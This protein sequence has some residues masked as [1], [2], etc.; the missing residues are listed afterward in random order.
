[1]V[2]LAE[3]MVSVRT[4]GQVSKPYP[5]VMVHWAGYGNSY[6]YP[7]DGVCQRQVVDIAILKEEPAGCEAPDQRQRSQDRVRQVRE[8]E[9]TCSRY[10]CG[11]FSWRQP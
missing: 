4:I 6:T 3:V 7:E 10:H 5:H 11:H 8:Y 1:M 2:S 9:Q